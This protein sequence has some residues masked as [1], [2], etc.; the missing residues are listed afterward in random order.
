MIPAPTTEQNSGKPIVSGNLLISWLVPVALVLLAMGVWSNHFDDSFHSDDFPR[1]VNNRALDTLRNIPRFFT[2]PRLASAEPEDADY[3][4]V[5]TSAFAIDRMFD[6]SD[7]PGFYQLDSLLWFAGLIFCLYLLFRLIPGTSHPIAMFGAAL[8]GLHPIT[9]ET[10]NYV[11][12]R[13]S[14]MAAGG[15]TL[16]LALRLIWPRRLPKKLGFDLNRVPQNWWQDVIR[17]NGLMWERSYKKLLKL[18]IPFYLIP[19]IPALFSDPSAAVFAPLLGLW[20]ILYGSART[21]SE[22]G[23]AEKKIGWLVPALVCG[24]YWIAQTFVVLRFSPFLRIPALSYLASQPWVALTYAARF[25][26]PTTITADSGLQA[27]GAPM[28]IAG[29]LGVAV[30]A[31]LAFWAGRR[32]TWRGVSFGLWWFL[33]CLLPGALVPQRTLDANSRMF[34]AAAGLALAIAHLGGIL[35]RLMQGREAGSGASVGIATGFAVAG[36]AVLGWLGW[37]THQRNEVWASEK[38]LWSDVIAKNPGNGRGYLMYSAAL[39]ADGDD[40]EGFKALEKAVPLCENDVSLQLGLARA[41]DELNKDVD[42]ELHYR[43]AIALAPS[44]TAYAYFGQWL[45]VHRRLEEA[46]ELSKKALALNPEDVV[47]HHTLMDLY[48]ERADWIQVAKLAK[49]TLALHPDDANGKRSLNVATASI[50][51]VKQAEEDVKGNPTVDDYLKL[52]VLYYN[53]RRYEECANAAK[54]ALR[55][56]PNQAEAYANIATAMHALGRDDEAIEAL[57]EVIR[58][59]PDMAFAKT[60]LEILLEARADRAKAQIPK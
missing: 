52:S 48:A 20:L 12:Q 4:P 58:L 16:A 8:F 38:T 40:I 60:D 59:R 49:E 28:V 23:V 7:S 22:K 24:I 35:F 15:V 6:S 29:F 30:I 21:V 5:L 37:M 41:F 51:Q 9:A 46:D 54:Q 13:G 11:S 47:A 50:D 17:T 42:A 43:R 55:L 31:G 53:G 34:L 32:E 27:V 1:I 57:R 33:I 44:S 2:Q 25:F 19:L 36:L 18:P 56:R 26:V 10:V 14:I 3:K 39:T 45:F